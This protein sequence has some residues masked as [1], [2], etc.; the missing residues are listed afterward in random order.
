MEKPE[1]LSYK[2]N[3]I[4]AVYKGE[5]M[6]ATGTATECAKELGVTADYIHFMV[7]PTGKRR[8]ASRKNPNKATTA[9]IIDF[10]RR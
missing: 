10:E 8:L 5:E 3:A 1:G 6:L 4:Y 2:N 9:D 7:T